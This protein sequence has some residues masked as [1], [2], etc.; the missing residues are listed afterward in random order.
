MMISTA[1]YTIQSVHGL[2]ETFAVNP[3]G[4]VDTTKPQ[5]VEKRQVE[6]KSIRMDE[7]QRQLVK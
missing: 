5:Q 7:R 2:K 1:T 6:S 3:D 4:K